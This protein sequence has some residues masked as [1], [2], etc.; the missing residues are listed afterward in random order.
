[1]HPF[2]LYFGILL[3]IGAPTFAR[4]RMGATDTFLPAAAGADEVKHDSTHDQKECADRNKIDHNHLPHAHCACFLFLRIKTVT[5]PAP[6]RTAASPARAAP[7][8]SVAG[9]TINVPTVYV[10]YAT[11]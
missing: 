8:E 9:A 11:V 1:M 2:Q 5:V 7:T 6:T 10:R 4:P 3:R